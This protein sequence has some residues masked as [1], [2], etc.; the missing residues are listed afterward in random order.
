MYTY[1]CFLLMFDRKQQNFVKQLPFI[2]K[3]G[4]K[5][6]KDKQRK[7]K[8][9][10]IFKCVVIKAVLGVLPKLQKIHYVIITCETIL[11]SVSKSKCF[12]PK[13]E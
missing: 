12:L 10:F 2:K 3:I 6:L 5:K 7:I 4:L 8:G 1:G 11:L 13:L 9:I